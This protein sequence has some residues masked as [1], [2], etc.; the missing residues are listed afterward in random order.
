VLND[1]AQSGFYMSKLHIAARAQKSSSALAAQLYS[2]S[3]AAGVVMIY[4][5]HTSAIILTADAAGI[6]LLYER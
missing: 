3:P 4:S 5:K 6:S 2:T 1:P